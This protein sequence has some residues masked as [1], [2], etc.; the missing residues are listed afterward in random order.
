M[1]QVSQ[2]KIMS[3]LTGGILVFGAVL[4]LGA[5]AASAN[6]IAYWRF[7]PGNLLVDSSG[8]GH[9]LTSTGTVTSVTDTDG[10]G[11]AGSGSAYF[12]GAGGLQTAAT[13][14]LTSY[15]KIKISWKQRVQGASAGVVWEHTSNFNLGG[16]A[17][18]SYVDSGNVQDVGI[19]F[20][21]DIDRF[22]H[23]ASA[24][25]GTWESYS[26]IFDL[27]GTGGTPA[28]SNVVQVF[29]GNGNPVT[30][31]QPY[32]LAPPASFRNAI[33]YIG[34]RGGSSLPLVGNIDELKIEDI[35]EP[36]T[37]ALL[38]MGG[39]MMVNFRGRGHRRTV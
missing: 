18:V 14:N 30:V 39:L 32:L 19:A 16:G 36:A 33:L 13:L 9:T 27:N 31:T 10:S 24:T 2:T 26:V 35:P 29:D 37:L 28:N 4:G 25:P 3:A 20:G 21:Y 5:T 38:A 22:T 6:T 17:F 34:Q 7:E 8:N 23:A 12:G 1:R 11:A 15:S